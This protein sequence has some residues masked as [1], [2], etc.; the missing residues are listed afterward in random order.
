MSHAEQKRAQA[1]EELEQAEAALRRAS[2]LLDTGGAIYEGAVADQQAS[3]VS[4]LAARL[5]P[6]T[7]DPTPAPFALAA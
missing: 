5:I 2:L 6:S 3:Q 7:P 1:R 4:C